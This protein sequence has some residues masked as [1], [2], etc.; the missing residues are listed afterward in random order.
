MDNKKSRLEAALYLSE[1]PLDREDIADV[2]N[3]GS[4][5]YVD[6]LLD[7]FRNDLDEDSRGLELV[8]SPMGYELRAA[9]KH[10]EHVRHLAPNQDLSEGVLRTMSLVAHNAPVMQSDIVEVRG[11]RAYQHIKQAVQ[12]GFIDKEKK[13]RSSELD[14]T[15]YFLD[16]FDVDR[17]DLDRLDEKEE[18][19]SQ[20]TPGLL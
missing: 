14:V 18:D 1:E 19:S 4:M 9:N 16:Y 7:E 13:G 20:D 6:M 17:Q 15:D 3:L 11:N 2:L 8:Q 5:G 10:L 12:R